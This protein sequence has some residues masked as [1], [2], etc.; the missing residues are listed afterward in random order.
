M[1]NNIEMKTKKVH[2]SSREMIILEAPLVRINKDDPT[3]FDIGS[4]KAQFVDT[5][6]PLA[7]EVWT[8]EFEEKIGCSVV[9]D[10]KGNIPNYYVDEDGVVQGKSKKMKME[11]II[12]KY[13]DR[14]KVDYPEDDKLMI[15][16]QDF[17]NEIKQTSTEVSKEKEFK[18]RR[19][20]NNG[21]NTHLVV[22]TEEAVEDIHIGSVVIVPYADGFKD[23]V[24]VLLQV[25]DKGFPKTLNKKFAIVSKYI[26]E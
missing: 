9:I 5:T 7:P 21:G 4:Y 24:K 25:D 2:H 11:N 13:I 19:F 15:D 6:N 10:P 23:P 16:L 20:T 8:E 22:V 18:C 26:Y 17:A 3:K 1:K 12:N 14:I